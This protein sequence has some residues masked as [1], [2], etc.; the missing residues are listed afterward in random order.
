MRKALIVMSLLCSVVTSCSVNSQSP[1]K[2][3][4]DFDAAYMNHQIRLVVVN[5]LSAF[6]TDSDVALLLEY[7]TTNKIVF[8][9]DYNLKLFIQQDDEWVVVKEKP[10]IRPDAPVVLSPNIPS[11]YGH[12]VG[13]WPQLDDLNKTY[14]MRAYVF[15][16]METKEGIH[17]V[18]TFADFILTP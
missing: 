14:R 16:D 17:Q 2:P 6:K 10:T 5:E 1:D 7:H 13:F 4:I 18:A 9:S 8:P 12:I 11:S 3:P 15:G